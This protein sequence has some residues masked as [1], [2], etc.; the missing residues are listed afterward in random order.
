M[1]PL[2]QIPMILFT[3]LLIIGPFC[4]Y[5]WIIYSIYFI[6]RN[7]ISSF[8]VIMIISL[9]LLIICIY[10]LFKTYLIEPGI[11]PR[12]TRDRPMMG[13][14]NEYEKFCTTCNIIRSSKAKHCS[15]CNNCVEGF[16]HHC[17]WVGTCVAQRNIRYFIGFIG[18][19][20]LL[21]LIV[22]IIS[23]TNIFILNDKTPFQTSFGMINVFI[24]LYAGIMAITLLG[25]T[26]N[27]YWMI[28]EGLTANEKIKYGQTRLT[29][30]ERQRNNNNNNN[31]NNEFY[32]NLR[33]AF[34][35]PL[36]P[37]QI[38]VV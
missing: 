32:L 38:F 9:L 35:Y 25:M 29:Q 26:I 7:N 27:Y 30:A 31:N 33:I 12:A 4:I 24:M 37:S 3:I 16:D 20:G 36:I 34:C 5:I 19:T 10:F 23:I 28:G 18:F 6:Q 14:L 22:A 8:I 17:P 15:I 11:I 13:P 21:G 1:G 2:I